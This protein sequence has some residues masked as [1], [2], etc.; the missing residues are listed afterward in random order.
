VDGTIK[1]SLLRGVPVVEFDYCIN[2]AVFADAIVEQVMAFTNQR[3]S[4]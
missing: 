4:A 1:K 3:Q 2:D